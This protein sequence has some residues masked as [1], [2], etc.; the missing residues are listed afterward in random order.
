M[1]R[2][3]FV[4]S[5]ISIF[6]ILMSTSWAES[7]SSP[8]AVAAQID[9]LVAAHWASDQITPAG[10]SDDAEFCRR[11][12]LDICGRIPPAS[13][14][15]DFLADVSPDKRSKLVDRLLDSPTYIV[16]YTNV[17]RAIIL[18]E[19]SSDETIRFFLPG[20]EA[21]LRSRLV[22][23]RNFAQIAE[24]LLTLPLD[25]MAMTGFQQPD[26]PSPIAFY[27]AKQGKPEEIA[28][29]SARM[30]L[31]VRI[32]CAQCHNH[33]FDKWK[34]E[35]F[36]SYAAFFKGTAAMPAPANVVEARRESSGRGR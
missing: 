1:S 10:V 6:A 20:F 33:P 18:P 13:E 22:E 5:A 15:R 24:E 16:N 9:T 21:W 32:E 4:S 7:P 23:N 28:G 31:G 36:W 35:E 3:R 27:R 17:W 11:V 14:V 8:Q 25:E 30:F 26:Q 12:H 29:A 34:R 2:W 19:S